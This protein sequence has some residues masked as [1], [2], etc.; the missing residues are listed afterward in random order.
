MAYVLCRRDLAQIGEPK[1]YCARP[2][3][4]KND[5]DFCDDCKSRRPFWALNNDGSICTPQVQEA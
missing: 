3:K 1:R 5:L 4:T 2:I